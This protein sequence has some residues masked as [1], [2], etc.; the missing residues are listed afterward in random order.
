MRDEQSWASRRKE[1]RKGR[2]N[3]QQ[4]RFFRCP[5]CS[6]LDPHERRQFLQRSRSSS[7]EIRRKKKKKKKVGKEMEKGIVEKI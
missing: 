7:M 6:E 3:V 2:K 4:Y 1:G 5:H